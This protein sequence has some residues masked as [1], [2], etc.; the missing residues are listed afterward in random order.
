MTSDY[1]KTFSHSASRPR[2]FAIAKAKT[3]S[4]GV[5]ALLPDVWPPTSPGKKLHAAKRAFSRARQ[6]DLHEYT[7]PHLKTTSSPQKMWKTSGTSTGP[8]FAYH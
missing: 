6:R 5:D 3:N 4:R 8:D 7:V 1:Q 2:L